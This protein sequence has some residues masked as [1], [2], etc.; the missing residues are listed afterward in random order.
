MAEVD[1]EETLFERVEKAASELD[2]RSM[3]PVT[4]EWDEFLIEYCGQGSGSHPSCQKE[5]AALRH[6]GRLHA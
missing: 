6:G 1:G 3:T 2:N 5:T 4:E